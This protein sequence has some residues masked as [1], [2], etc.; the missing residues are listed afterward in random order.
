[1]VLPPR[2][3]TTEEQVSLIEIVH[4][5]GKQSSSFDACN[6]ESE[7]CLDSLSHILLQSN[8]PVTRLSLC[9]HYALNYGSLKTLWLRGYGD[10]LVTTLNSMNVQEIGYMTGGVVY[11]FGKL[12]VDILDKFVVCVTFA[13]GQPVFDT[14]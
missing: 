8:K 1:M 13:S 11:V 10:M 9:G 6:P 7:H 2:L 12:F 14:H 3:L 4:L 5:I